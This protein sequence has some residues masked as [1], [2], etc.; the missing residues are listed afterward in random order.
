MD[1]VVAGRADHEGLASSSRHEVRPW[2]LW[3]PRSAEVGE[4]ADVVDFDLAGVL[5]QLTSSC[6]E[7][8]DQLGAADDARGWLA[9]GEDRFPLLFQGEATEGGGQ[10]FLAGAFDNHLQAGAWPVRC[11]DGG[12]VTGRHLRH[13]GVAPCR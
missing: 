10:R 8:L 7:P 1:V 4:L 6:L 2:R 13:R 11:V 12:L 5:A 9:V 3:L